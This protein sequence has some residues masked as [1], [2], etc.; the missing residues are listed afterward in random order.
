M[1]FKHRY[2]LE[3]HFARHGQEFRAAT[4]D[5]YESL[6]EAFMMGP[7]RDGVRECVRAN[8]DLVRFDPRTNEFGILS[9]SGCIAT[10]MIV[11]P[12][13]SSRKTSLQYFLE[14]CE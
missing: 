7:L 10:F 2:D 6:A 14:Q 11:R 4:A 9:T 8:G 5:E 1:A 13:A 12:L 3:R